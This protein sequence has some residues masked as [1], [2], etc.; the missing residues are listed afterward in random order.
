MEHYYTDERNAQILISL[1]KAHNV[2]K[3]IASPGTTNICF[4]ASLQQDPYF[5]VY[6]SPEERSAGYMA[7]G[8]AAESGEAVAICCTGATASRNYMPALTEAFYRKLPILAI[9]ASR[10]NYRIGHNFDQVTDRTLLPRDIAKL[11]VQMPLVYDDES[12]WAN[13]IAANKALLELNHHGSGP[14][15]I[16]LETNYSRN[17][18]IKKL[19]ETKAI[20]RFQKGDRIPQINAEKI[21]IRVGAHVRWDDTLIKAVDS[22]CEAYNAV[23][24]C[25][26][27]SNYTGKYRF[28]ATMVCKQ[29]EYNYVAKSVD[30]IIHIGDIFSD[31]FY[32]SPQNVWRVNPDGE[33][34]DTFYKLQYVFEFTEEDFFNSYLEMSTERRGIGFFEN[35]MRDATKIE[36]RLPSFLHQLPFSNAWAASQT[37]HRLPENSVLHLG[38]QNSLRFWNYFDTPSSVLGYSNTGGFGIDGSMSSTIGASLFDRSK[39]YFCVLGD[40]AFFYDLNS[41]GNRHVGNNIRIMLINNGKGAEFKLSGNPGAMFGDETDTYIAAAGHYGNKS[42]MLVKHYAE[43]LDFEYLSA[44][45]KEEFMQVIDRFI[46]PEISKKPMIFEVFTE[47]SCEDEAFNSLSYIIKDEQISA[48][49]KAKNVMKKVLGESN[50]NAIKEM[51]KGH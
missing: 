37:A 42:T 16:N 49:R 35:C 12:E 20:Y 30:L 47:S 5:E 23:V 1:M 28:F 39:I 10:R 9:T 4:V 25:D 19:P 24:L 36:S 27:I 8:L 26:H 13:M 6:S 2:K 29:K 21:A 50:T 33:L 51:L 31:A 3:V 17:Y 22:F 34:R 44:S 48:K 46:T 15:H 41:L 45:N 43:D 7:C 11:S 14:V 18:N 38:I 40:L 32:I